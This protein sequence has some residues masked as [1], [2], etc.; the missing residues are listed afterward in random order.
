MIYYIKQD[1]F[2][3]RNEISYWKF[4]KSTI[5]AFRG[6]NLA[7]YMYPLC[8]PGYK[9]L[10][11]CTYNKSIYVIKANSIFLVIFYIF[12]GVIGYFTFFDSNEGE[13]IFSYYP[14]G[15]PK[16]LANLTLILMMVF[17]IPSGFT[18]LKYKMA[19]GLAVEYEPPQLI[20]NFMGIGFA[21]FICFSI[22]FNDSIFP[23]LSIGLDI[24]ASIYGFVIPVIFYWKYFSFKA[25]YLNSFYGIILITFCLVQVCLVFYFI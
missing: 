19:K 1:E 25:S 15:L 14:D 6:L 18:H 12:L 10:L 4:D 3:P 17:T 23:F 20:Q 8:Y 16:I 5:V 7:F 2:D 21:V 11:G 13:I 24:T 9:H 22:L